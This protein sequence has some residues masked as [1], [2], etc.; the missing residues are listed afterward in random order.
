MFL[1][2]QETPAKLV[3]VVPFQLCV[4]ELRCKK[5]KSAAL[6]LMDFARA[7]CGCHPSERQVAGRACL[8]L[9]SG[10]LWEACQRPA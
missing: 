1:G 2:G 4:A 3:K 10:G 7:E 8:E 5:V 9:V 6:V